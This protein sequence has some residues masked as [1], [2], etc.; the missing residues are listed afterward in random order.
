MKKVGTDKNKLREAIEQTKNYI[1]VSGTYNLTPEDHNGL[2]TDS[3]I[4]V[5]VENGKWKL[6][7]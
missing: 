5:R 6:A 7:E 2:G 3:M 1:G 4:M